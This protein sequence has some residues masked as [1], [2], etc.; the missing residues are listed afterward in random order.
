[1]SLKDIMIDLRKELEEKTIIHEKIKN[2]ARKILYLSKQVIMAIHNEKMNEAKVKLNQMVQIRS[3]LGE[4]L[5]LNQELYT[6]FVEVALQEYAE[7]QGFLALVEKRGYIYPKELNLSTIP[8]LLGLADSIGEFRRRALDCLRKGNLKEAKTALAIMEDI[9]GELISLEKAYVLAP[10]LRRKCD[11]AR[12]LIEL[13][14]GDITRDTRRTS[15][16]KIMDSLQ[17]QITKF[18]KR[19]M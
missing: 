13:T 5:D 6:K 7:A 19:Q 12:R 17:D 11:I 10:E 3:G 15:L 16:L 4:I 1:M 2:A 8:Y 14:I 9:Y 18:N